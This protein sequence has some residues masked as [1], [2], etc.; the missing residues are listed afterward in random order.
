MLTLLVVAPFAAAVISALGS[1]RDRAAAS[2]IGLVLAVVLTVLGAVPLLCTGSCCAAV[3]VPWFQLWGSAATVHFALDCSGPGAWLAFLTL[4]LGAP[5]ILISRYSVGER[6]REFTSLLF[7]LQG[8]LVG[9]FLAADAVL[10][11]VFF[12]AGLLPMAALIALFGDRELRVAATS[13]F[14][15]YTMFGS[16]F[17]LVALWYLAVMG[18]TTRLV[19]L[20]A[21]IAETL[22]PQARGWCFWAFA[23]AFAVKTPLLPF[24]GWQ[25]PVYQAC[26][27]GAAAVLA[28]AMAKLGTYG[29]LVLVLP[30]FPDESRHFSG[31]FITLGVIGVVYGALV[32]L[33]QRDIKRLLAFSSLSHLGL[34]V[35]GIFSFEAAA[36]DGAV[37]QMIAHGLGVGALFLLVAH[38]EGRSGAR[39]LADFGALAGRAPILAILVVAAA[40]CAVGLPGTAAFIGEVQLLAGLFVSAYASSLTCAIVMTAVAGSSLILGA[41]YVLR[42]VQKILYGNEPGPASARVTDVAPAEGLA[43]ATL[44]VASLVLGLLP[45]LITDGPVRAGAGADS[46]GCAT[47]ACALPEVTTASAVSACAVSKAAG[48]VSCPQTEE[49]VR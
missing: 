8:C 49:A 11:Y 22:T 17:M 43:I 32:A 41:V 35:A 7:V 1:G 24:H 21:V 16:I 34:V 37:V 6:L 13:R 29:F 33:A 4:L 45:R 12:E 5:A 30:L 36:H 46:A 20:P 48:C 18:G 9:A 23:L 10:F 19:D 44:L 27:G 42:A 14:I 28:G 47:A 25:A 39:T 38:I 15:I 3:D 2:R 31:L 26:P 40:L